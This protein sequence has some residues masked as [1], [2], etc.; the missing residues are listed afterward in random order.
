MCTIW[1]N[2]DSIAS[3]VSAIVAVVVL[4]FAWKAYRHAKIIG[5]IPLRSEIANFLLLARTVFD[6]VCVGNSVKTQ[7]WSDLEASYYRLNLMIPPNNSVFERLVEIYL[8]MESSLEKY[9]GTMS[10]RQGTLNLK[11][12]CDRDV[13][14]K[15]WEELNTKLT[16]KAREFLDKI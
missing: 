15:I 8:H 5:T 13:W 7:I 2:L 9:T 12:D 16:E 1:N 11:S 14:K 6:G 10:S 4:F 3:I